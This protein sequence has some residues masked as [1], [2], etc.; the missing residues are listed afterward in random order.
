VAPGVKL[1]GLDVFD[2]SGSSY[3]RIAKAVDWA[4]ANKAKYNIT[5]INLSLGGEGFTGTAR[6][7]VAI[8]DCTEVV[9]RHMQSCTVQMACHMG[10]NHVTAAILAHARHTTRVTGTGP[11]R[12]AHAASPAMPHPEPHPC[13]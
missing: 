5:A 11:Q 4:A 7:C 1:I 3:A 6:W 9:C 2:K 12:R 13:V 8:F 10:S